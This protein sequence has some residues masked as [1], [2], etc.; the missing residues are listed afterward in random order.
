MSS[1]MARALLMVGGVLMGILVMSLLVYWFNLLGQYQK[2]TEEADYR[3][4]Q[5]LEFNDKIL[6]ADGGSAELNQFDESGDT[7]KRTN[8]DFGSRS[9][10][11]DLI[12]AISYIYDTNKK[13]EGVGF[14]ITAIISG[15]DIGTVTI[16]NT[17]SKKEMSNQMYTLLQKLTILNQANDND[18][19][20]KRYVVTIDR[21][22]GNIQY[23]EEGRINKMEMN[24]YM[25]NDN[26]IKTII[27]IILALAILTLILVGIISNNLTRENKKQLSIRAF[28]NNILEG[29]ERITGVQLLSVINKIDEQNKKEENKIDIE[30][31]RQDLKDSVNILK[32]NNEKEEKEETKRNI[33]DL[34][35]QIPNEKYKNAG[36]KDRSKYPK[37]NEIQMENIIKSG[38][39]NFTENLGKE[40]FERVEVKYNERGY[41]NKVIYRIVEKEE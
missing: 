8:K 4:R 10:I 39:N 40:F 38:F 28:N 33:A 32:I 14:D 34:V 16:K 1:N 18:K 2:G 21:S 23:T 5:V 27:L 15:D 11:G 19:T 30:K 13:Y 41:I 37:Y 29:N 24:S 26:T 17:I 22:Q 31:E 36:V 12:S 25:K 35:I 6:M 3:H 7:K 9:T 20:L